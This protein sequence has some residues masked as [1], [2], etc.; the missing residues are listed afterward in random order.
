MFP[1]GVGQ[2]G[3]ITL[4]AA[5]YRFE[6]ESSPAWTVLFEISTLVLGV[7][8]GGWMG[9]AVLL[10]LVGVREGMGLQSASLLTTW[11]Q[12]WQLAVMTGVEMEM[13]AAVAGR[14]V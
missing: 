10:V 5:E 6:P 8:L 13:E 2:A 11:V 1:L 14:V 9:F 7:P 12:T 4:R 3:D